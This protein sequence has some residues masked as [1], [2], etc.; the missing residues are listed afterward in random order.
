[1]LASPSLLPRAPHEQSLRRLPLRAPRQG[2]TSHRPRTVAPA[3]MPIMPASVVG[4]R[5]PEEVRGGDLAA[6]VMP[7]KPSNVA[8]WTLALIPLVAEAIRDDE[9]S[10]YE[11]DARFKIL[12]LWGFEV[13]SWLKY[14]CWPRH[15]LFLVG[16]VVYALGTY[17][18]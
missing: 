13:S 12:W 18:R 2:R 7:K 16:V 1:M 5:S 3:M 6:A 15:L 10:I 8:I 11:I 14:F 9:R 17:K 4:A